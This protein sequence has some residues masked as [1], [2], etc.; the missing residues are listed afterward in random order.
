MVVGQG[1]NWG[2]SAKDKKIVLYSLIILSLTLHDSVFF[3][4]MG[5]DLRHQVLRPLMA[6]CT[7]PNDRCG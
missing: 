2:C 5:W 4:F 7:A 3:F 1:P 6:Y